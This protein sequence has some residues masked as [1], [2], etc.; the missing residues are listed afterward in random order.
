MHSLHSDKLLSYFTNYQFH[1][2][3]SIIS[4]CRPLCRSPHRCIQYC[5]TNLGGNIT[6]SFP[7]IQTE[8][9][10]GEKEE[11][12]ISTEARGLNIQTETMDKPTPTHT[13]VQ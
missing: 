1:K 2:L 12:V 4:F 5:C 8:E 13:R 3:F 9:R 7:W 6:L 11:R 10:R